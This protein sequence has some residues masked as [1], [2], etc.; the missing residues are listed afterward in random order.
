MLTFTTFIALGAKNSPI[1][2]GLTDAD[3]LHTTLGTVVAEQALI[4]NEDKTSEANN[5]RLSVNISD[6]VTS[7][8]NTRRSILI[9]DNAIP[10]SYEWNCLFINPSVNCACPS[11]YSNIC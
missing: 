6:T 4:P 11:G 10:I 5:V 3:E 8:K 1:K 2:G 9:Y 7:G